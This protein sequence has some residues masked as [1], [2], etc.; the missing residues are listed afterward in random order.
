MLPTTGYFL[1]GELSFQAT[2]PNLVSHERC[3]RPHVL[4]CAV[5]TKLRMIQLGLGVSEVCMMIQEVRLSFHLRHGIAHSSVVSSGKTVTL[6][7]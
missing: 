1:E 2:V 7:L 6:E 5:H 3:P 4:S